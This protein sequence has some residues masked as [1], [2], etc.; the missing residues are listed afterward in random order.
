[1]HSQNG[2]GTSLH[3]L[4]LNIFIFELKK[5]KKK[6]CYLYANSFDV[7]YILISRLLSKTIVRGILILRFLKL[8][9][10]TAKLSCNKVNSG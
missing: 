7:K 8:H 4:N 5:L 2:D 6:L 3:L 9:R 10:K 1:V